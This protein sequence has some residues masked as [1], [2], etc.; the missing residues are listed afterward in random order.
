MSQITSH[1]S[2]L[3]T[4]RR[5]TGMIKY[6]PSKTRVTTNTFPRNYVFYHVQGSS[7]HCYTNTIRLWRTLEFLPHPHD[8]ETRFAID[9]YSPSLRRYVVLGGEGVELQYHPMIGPYRLTVR[10]IRF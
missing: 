2:A 1:Q 10:I 3:L 4:V 5:V 9:E 8:I 7:G 6:P